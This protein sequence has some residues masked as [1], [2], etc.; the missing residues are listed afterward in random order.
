MNPFLGKITISTGNFA[1]LGWALCNG[2]FLAISQN[3]ALISI[4]GTTYGGDGRTT[5]ALPDLRVRASIQ[6]GTG[7]WLST[8]T[9]GSREGQETHTLNTL[10]IPSH[11]HIANPLLN[12][13]RKVQLL[14]MML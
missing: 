1:P 10:E 7:P 13:M 8:R 5:F 9:L 12:F 11:N 3:N 2:Q 6:S 14:T 4:I